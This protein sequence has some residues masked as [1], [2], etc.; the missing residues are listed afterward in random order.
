MKPPKTPDKQLPQIAIGYIRGA[1]I[2]GKFAESLLRTVVYDAATW[3]ILQAR[4]Q[5]QF[6]A[7]YLN[8]GR[9][10]LTTLMCDQ[11]A[12][13]CP[14]FVSL[15]TDHSFTPQQ[16]MHLVSLVDPVTRPVVSGLYFACDGQGKQVRPVMLRRNV[17]GDLETMWDYPENQLVE[18]D[19]VGMGFC[20]ISVP[21]LLRM[22][23]HNGD[24]WYDFDET[25]HGLFMPEDNAFCA[26]IQEF[27]GGKIHVH[28]GIVVG[29]EKT[30]LLGAE[31]QKQKTLITKPGDN[32]GHEPTANPASPNDSNV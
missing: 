23:E 16:V 30:V 14:V 5:P 32:I 3:N 2:S 10:A 28:T 1:Q 18:V 13:S 26:R 15:D 9:N 19:V 20:A 24:H 11:W 25:V 7:H 21:W 12:E 22:R 4:V 27:L 6:C 29:H 17:N 8:I 31:H